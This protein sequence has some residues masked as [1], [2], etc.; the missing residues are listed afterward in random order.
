MNENRCIC[1][2]ASIPE[3][4]MVCPTCEA[5]A[6]RRYQQKSG[7][8]LTNDKILEIVVFLMAIAWIV[9]LVIGKK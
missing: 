3:G 8:W 6:E 2:G 5:K 9:T 7:G 4:R 1:C